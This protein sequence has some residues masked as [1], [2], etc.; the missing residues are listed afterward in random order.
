MPLAELLRELARA[1]VATQDELDR[2]FV[3]SR[4]GAAARG[5]DAPPPLWYH[6][7][8]VRIGLGMRGSVEKAD[9][10]SRFVC[11]LPDPLTVALYGSEPVTSTWIAVELGPLRPPAGFV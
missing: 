6:F 2:R 9:E 5:D 10:S 7:E 11:Q 1:V 8:G 4:A 3:A